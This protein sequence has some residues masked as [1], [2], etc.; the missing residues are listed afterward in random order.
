MLAEEQFTISLAAQYH[1]TPEIPSFPSWAPAAAVKELTAMYVAA[2]ATPPV[3]TAAI[4]AQ[5]KSLIT[6]Y[7]VGYYDRAPDPAGLAYWVNAYSQP[8]QPFYQNISQIAASFADPKQPETTA[9]YPF[10]ANPSHGL[11]ADVMSFVTTAYSNLFGRNPGSSDSGVDYWATSIA[12]SLKIPVPVYGNPAIDN[13]APV[14]ASE[15]LIALILGATGNDAATIANKV[16]VG[17]YYD[18]ALASYRAT[19]TPAM[20]K[21]ALSGVT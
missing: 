1:V 5:T 11:Y 10:L 17:E 21:A 13:T 7:Y 4:L 14:S 18:S 12:K 19:S 15:A 16:T 6:Q 9:L 20:E 8:S 3:D 2:G